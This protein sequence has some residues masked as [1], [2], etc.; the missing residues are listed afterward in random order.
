MEAPES[1]RERDTI[2]IELKRDT[3]EALKL[4]KVLFNVKSYDLLIKL[5]VATNPEFFTEIEDVKPELASRII[6][7]VSRVLGE[8]SE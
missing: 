2:T 6:K 3:V 4:L 7:D 5:L 1:K 8:K